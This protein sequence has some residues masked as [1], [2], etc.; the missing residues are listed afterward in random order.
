MIYLG[1]FQKYSSTTFLG[2][3]RWQKR[4]FFIEWNNVDGKFYLM[5]CIPNIDM[6]SSD[7]IVLDIKGRLP[8]R[9]YTTD[10]IFYKVGKHDDTNRN[11]ITIY[12]EDG[13]ER[14]YLELNRVSMLD[15]LTPSNNLIRILGYVN[16][17]LVLEQQSKLKACAGGGK[18][19]F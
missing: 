11:Y 8:I 16:E 3:G 17:L 14:P 13:T 7:N 4:S 6:S 1:D 12:F 19:Y 2:M 10:D 9:T 15:Q 5:Y 18:L